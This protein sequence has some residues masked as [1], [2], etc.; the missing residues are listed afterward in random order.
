MMIERIHWIDLLK[1]LGIFFVI[2]G[3]TIKNNDLYVW[4]YS[5]HMPLFFF[6]S[7]YLT[8]PRNSIKDYNQ[9]IWKK[10]KNLLFP[11]FIFRIL[12]VFIGLLL[13]NILDL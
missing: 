8:E 9:Y 11:F 2:L 13:N 5:F 6:I 10:C 1:G 3:H 4:I 12:L 7:G